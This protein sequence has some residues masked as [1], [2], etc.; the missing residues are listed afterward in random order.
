MLLGKGIGIGRSVTKLQDGRTMVLVTNFRNEP[1]HLTKGMAVALVEN[2]S[3]VTNEFAA[4]EVS[5]VPGPEKY[6][7]R[8]RESSSELDFNPKL[9]CRDKNSSSYS[10]NSTTIS[11]CHPGFAKR[12]SQS[13]G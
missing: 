3:D 12:Q 13:T 7:G 4:A 5:R 2:F 6:P 1:Q 8:V 10:T 11:P 9:S